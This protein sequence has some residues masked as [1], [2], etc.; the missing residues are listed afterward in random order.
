MM[1]ALY[2]NP[3]VDISLHVD[4]L[5]LTRANKSLFFFLLD[6]ACLEEK[7]QLPIA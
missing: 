6:I 7:Q 5:S 2:N 4:T 3:P 1:F